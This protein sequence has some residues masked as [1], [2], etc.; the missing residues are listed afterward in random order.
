MTR[1]IGDTTSG[2]TLKQANELGIDRAPQI[3]IFGDQSYRDDT[4]IDGATF[5]QNLKLHLNY[6][7]PPH[8]H[9]FFIIRFSTTCAQ[10]GKMQ[11]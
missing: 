4:E 8:R 2:I 9:Q 3:V 7:K 5:I 6:Q 11:S 1:I 10:R